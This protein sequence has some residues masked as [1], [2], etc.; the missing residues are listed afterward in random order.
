MPNF[1]LSIYGQ[2]PKLDVESRLP[3]HLFNNLERP[4][5]FIF[6]G[7]EQATRRYQTVQLALGGIFVQK[8]RNTPPAQNDFAVTTASATYDSFQPISTECGANPMNRT[9]N[10]LIVVGLSAF[11]LVST[12]FG[13]SA[14]AT[15]LA[16]SEHCR[17][18]HFLGGW[19]RTTGMKR[20]QMEHFLF[21][22]P[23]EFRKAPTAASEY[24]VA[25]VDQIGSH[26]EYSPNKFWV[27]LR[28][29]K[30]R[31]AR[32]IEWESGQLVQQS[33]HVKGRFDEPKTEEGVLVEGKLFRKS[34]PQWP[35]PGEHARVSPNEK[36]I[37]VQS[38]EG[39]D[40][41]NG[42][43]VAPRENLESFSST[44]TRCLPSESLLQSRAYTEVPFV[45][46]YR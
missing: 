5:N 20:G 17:A 30:V 10:S 6:N 46:M 31:S 23:Y 7:A 22:Y 38:W 25:A 28:S 11:V 39:H 41:R 13:Q 18:V 26:R 40:Y 36:W 12:A 24:M 35:I 33:S 19:Q 4:S 8:V 43:I 29:G 15:V 44:C 27:N 1:V 42:D 21:G 16:G 9:I 37:A 34:G 32:Q 14:S 2:F 3:L 45:P